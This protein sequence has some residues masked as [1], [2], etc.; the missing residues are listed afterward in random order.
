MI[1]LEQACCGFLAFELRGAKS[2]L[3]VT[4]TAPEQ[5]RVAAE[6]LFDQFVAASGQAASVDSQP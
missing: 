5:A 4:I 1:A 6:T 3:W 2:E